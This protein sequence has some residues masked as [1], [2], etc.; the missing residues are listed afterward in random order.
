[1]IAGVGGE[2]SVRSTERTRQEK[3]TRRKTQRE[4]V[5]ESIGYLLVAMS[6]W[7]DDGRLVT[8]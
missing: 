5:S 4:R 3:G 6:I 1:M 2:I 7:L 8:G